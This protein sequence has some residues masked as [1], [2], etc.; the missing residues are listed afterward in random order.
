MQPITVSL[1]NLFQADLDAKNMAATQQMAAE[2]LKVEARLQA[3]IEVLAAEL[4]APPGQPVKL[5]PLTEGVMKMQQAGY[6]PNYIKQLLATQGIFKI[7][8][9]PQPQAK[10]I[11]DWQLAKLQR[12]VRLLAQ[13]QAEIERFTGKV[14]TPI[15]DK[16]MAD[17]AYAGLQNHL[18][19]MNATLTGS[20]GSAIDF[21]FD[22]LGIEA[23]QNIVALA[24][25]GQPLGNLLQAAYPLAAGGITDR[26]IYGTATGQNPRQTA[27]EIVRD[28]LAQGLNHILLVA[29]DQQVRSYREAGRQAYLKAGIPGYRRLAAHQSRTCLACL[30][31]DGTI[32]PTGELMPLHPEDRCTMQPIIPGFAPIQTESGEAW[33]SR[34]TPETQAKM[35]G[36]GKYAAW[37]AGKFSFG[38]LATVKR[39]PIWGPNSQV[40]S[41]KDLLG[42]KGGYTPPALPKPGPGPQPA[43]SLLPGLDHEALMKLDLHQIGPNWG[44]QTHWENQSYGGVIFDAEG[45]VLLR[46]PTGNFDGYAWTFPK[47][48]MDWPGEHPVL[49][50][51]REVEQETGHAGA[52][53]GLVPGQYQ[54]SPGSTKNNFFLMKSQGFDVSKMDAE[55][56]ELIW[57]TPEEARKLIKQGKNKAGVERDLKIL[58]AATGAYSDL[59]TG[60][61]TNDYLFKSQKSKPIVITTFGEALTAD[62]KK[63]AG[64]TIAKNA[65]KD[66]EQN[67]NGLA[68]LDDSGK[69]KA[70]VSFT[71]DEDK[72]LH[73]NAAWADNQVSAKTALINVGKL[74]AKQGKGL[75]VQINPSIYQAAKA[76]GLEAG[77]LGKPHPFGTFFL[78]PEWMKDWAKAPTQFS[79]V[80]A[81]KGLTLPEPPPPPKAYERKEI[82]SVTYTALD[83]S[84]IADPLAKK[85]AKAAIDKALGGQQ[86]FGYFKEG[87]L[88]GVIS[89]EDQ[90]SLIKV[91]SAGFADFE[92]NLTGLQ[93]VVKVAQKMG[94]DLVTFA[95]SGPILKQYKKWGFQTNNT[96][97]NGES[98]LLSKG[99]FD[100]WLKDPE[101][102]LEA[103]PTTPTLKAPTPKP[104]KPAPPASTFKATPKPR[105]AE[106]LPAPTPL[107]EPEGF[108]ADPLVL[109]VARRLGGSTGAELVQAADG[110]LYVR[111]R[112]NSADHVREEA[113][114]D[115]AYQAAGVNVPRFR[116]YETDGGPV[117]LAEYIEGETLGEVLRRGG[118]KAK[119]ARQA[120]QEAFAADA[121]FSNRDVVGQDY[122]NILVDKQ[123]RVWRIDNGGSFRFRAQGARKQD[124]D[125]YAT[126]LWTMRDQAT[127]AQTG[128]V[129]TGLDFYT[130]SD[131]VLK[132]QA[133]REAI[134]A[135]VSPEVQE[136]LARR[137][138]HLRDMAVTGKDL[139]ADSYKVDYADGFSKNRMELRQAGV[140]DRMSLALDS[141]ES[142]TRVR[143]TRRRQ[144]EVVPRDE[145]GKAFDNLHGE[146]GVVRDVKDFIQRNGGS[147]SII[148]HWA[149]QQ[150]GDS[151]ND[152]PA[153]YKYW[154]ANNAVNVTNPEDEFFWRYGYDNARGCYQDQVKKKGEETYAKTMRAYH[155]FVY[156]VVSHME[157]PNR[158]EASRTVHVYRTEN[159]QVM[160]ENGLKP[161]AESVTMKR[162]A[163]ESA[164]IF[165]PVQIYGTEVT[166]Q[167]VPWHRVL[168]V[169]FT[170]RSPGSNHGPFLGDNEN[171]FVVMLRDIPFEY[172]K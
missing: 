93:D 101:T 67:G 34:Q 38:Q 158:D 69:M 49:T 94:K 165:R 31:L 106:P 2:W 120:V 41:L 78:P 161:G 37:K 7:P 54:T 60:A 90:G 144:Y 22:R 36:P 162:G 100:A 89:Y 53:L 5:D 160:R 134:L 46:Q 108:P 24:G 151:W 48:R 167:D 6:A 88:K 172:V 91:G 124:W 164:S 117:K 62:L 135:A 116:L 35:M 61:A 13:T 33:F 127:N 145:N 97:T 77:G 105:P 19:L 12:Y 20:G 104:A 29:R 142:K 44:E 83:E 8:E 9:V 75:T 137:L 110:K 114:A 52:I 171:E 129:F 87:K 18:T 112:G 136:T 139:Q 11:K 32:Y 168:G 84:D 10:Q 86:G 96:Y 26:L 73:A 95:P 55:T 149:S 39:N 107:P 157:F 133:R 131:Q 143:N 170:E 64:A 74:A 141:P 140:K 138:G 23:V 85:G 68:V 111:K 82:F 25:A 115:A 103:S 14:A 166:E 147:Y 4:A 102:P 121:L 118:A 130:I 169:Y 119:A 154:L 40:T 56:E 45:R 51:L 80:K 163:A 28:G 146:D 30:A 59:Q 152:A 66:I 43:P 27:R 92:T 123:G 3:E 125:E 109:P 153:A 58:I 17:S 113:H 1:T 159:I 122:D 65:M 79:K 63:Q 99:N 156:E 155:A 57:A 81:A 126:D 15:L 150:G 128:D 16:L 148:E 21:A 132:L 50:A 98:L 71:A 47:G 42:G 72:Y 70:I 76:L